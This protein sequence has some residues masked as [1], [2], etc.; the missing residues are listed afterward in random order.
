M[1]KPI[2]TRTSTPTGGSRGGNGKPLPAPINAV[3]CALPTPTP[4]AVMGSSHHARR[5][6]RALGT[7]SAANLAGAV[8]RVCGW[9]RLVELGEG[10]A[11]HGEVGR[12]RLSPE[13]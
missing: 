6:R 5:Q 1:H 4:C 12:A 9:H 2:S 3:P 8:E 13:I 10:V 7:P 11:R